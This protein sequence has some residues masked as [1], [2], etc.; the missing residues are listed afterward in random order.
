MPVDYS[1]YLVTDGTPAIL[2]KRKLEDVI[3][4]A[5]AGGVTVVQYRDKHSETATLIE[6]TKNLLKICQPNG[7]PLIINDRVDVALA[8]GAQGVHLGQTDMSE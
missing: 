1:L 8:T 3:K 5:M 6:T 4:A 2:G 7:V